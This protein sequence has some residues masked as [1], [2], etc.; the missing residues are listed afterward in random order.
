MD[1]PAGSWGAAA[2]AGPVLLPSYRPAALQTAVSVASR[3]TKLNAILD[4]ESLGNEYGRSTWLGRGVELAFEYFTAR[5]HC[6][7]IVLPAALAAAA[8]P[9]CA[10]ALARVEDGDPE[11]LYRQPVSTTARVDL[12]THAVSSAQMS[13]EPTVLVSNY[14]FYAEVA[15]QTGEMREDCRVYLARYRIGFSWLGD[16]FIPAPAP[17][18]LGT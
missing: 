13:D 8:P 15:G 17:G 10:A 3:A 5:G 16:E 11:A 6:V 4:G 14:T 12:L 7:Q 9:A 2:E 18:M 1:V